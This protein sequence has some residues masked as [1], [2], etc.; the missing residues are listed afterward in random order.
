MYYDTSWYYIS[1]TWARQ[2]FCG[3]VSHNGCSTRKLGRPQKSA[4]QAKNFS[5][6]YSIR[7]PFLHRE[8][9]VLGGGS[10]PA[11]PPPCVRHCTVVPYFFVLGYTSTFFFM[12]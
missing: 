6:K 2:D 11:D 3:D 10:G 4:P 7:K 1:I 5:W 12:V 9:T 8:I